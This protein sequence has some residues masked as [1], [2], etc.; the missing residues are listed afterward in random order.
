MAAPPCPLS[1]GWPTPKLAGLA[2]QV[3]AIAVAFSK[4]YLRQSRTLSNSIFFMALTNWRAQAIT[5]DHRFMGL[6]LNGPTDLYR[7][8]RRVRVVVN[9]R[10]A[11]PNL[12][13]PASNSRQRKPNPSL[14]PPFPA[15]AF[16]RYRFHLHPLFSAPQR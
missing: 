16:F 9:P 6:V 8:Q 11:P 15:T 14:G 1:P 12:V 5:P 2:L 3:R 13:P 10:P 7:I 4:I